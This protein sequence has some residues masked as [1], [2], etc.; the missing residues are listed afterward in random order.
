MLNKS[1]SVT[2]GWQAAEIIHRRLAA[3]KLSFLLHFLSR[4]RSLLSFRLYYYFGKRR[5]IALSIG[6]PFR[7]PLTVV[8]IPLHFRR[9]MSVCCDYDMTFM[10]MMMR[11]R[12]GGLIL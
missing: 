10:F 4:N 3:H 9:K 1:Y 6:I 12:L 2:G 11:L 7:C 8:P 5:A